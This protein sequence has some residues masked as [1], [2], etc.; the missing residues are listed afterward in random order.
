MVTSVPSPAGAVG[1]AVAVLFGADAKSAMDE[2]LDKLQSLL[3][4]GA[5]VSGGQTVTRA[6]FGSGVGAY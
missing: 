6:G 2:D 3:E 1:D 4:T 5:T